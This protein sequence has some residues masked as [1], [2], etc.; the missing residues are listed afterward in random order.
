MQY[1]IILNGSQLG[2][3]SKEE[4]SLQGITSE[5]LVWHEGLPEWVKANT[6]PELSDLLA[7][8]NYAE[9]YKPYRQEGPENQ[10][11]HPQPPVNP[12]YQPG[13][14]GYQQPYNNPYGQPMNPGYQQNGYPIPHTN[15]MPWAI[16]T[17]IVGTC[18]TCIGLVLG[19]IAIVY[20][21]KANS[22]YAAGQQ[23]EGDAANS[24]A[25]I[26]TIINIVLCVLGI[27]ASV[28]SVI[29]ILPL[30]MLGL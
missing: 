2:P 22:C 21:S 12:G 5:T 7:Q 17:T 18:T 1:Y 20:A 9:N 30:M 11:K 8:A 10:P 23:V 4:L 24:T 25:R 26:L 14:Q 29:S 6:V 3:Y 19:I 15:W 28:F 16:I 27:I 13:Q